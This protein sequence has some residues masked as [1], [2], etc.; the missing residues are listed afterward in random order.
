MI[1][2]LTSYSL[3]AGLMTF[4]CTVPALICAAVAVA[5]YGNRIAHA[6]N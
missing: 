6:A 4:G 5:V 3:A 2:Y 1:L